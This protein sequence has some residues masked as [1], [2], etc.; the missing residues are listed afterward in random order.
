MGL[1]LKVLISLNLNLQFNPCKIP[2]RNNDSNVSNER[3]MKC[4]ISKLS[5]LKDKKIFDNNLS[6]KAYNE[7][8]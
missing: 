1:F 7:A 8:R 3:M 6:K 4:Q 5:S 2:L